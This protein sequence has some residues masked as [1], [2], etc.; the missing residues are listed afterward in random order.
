LLAGPATSAVGID[1]ADD[2]L[3]A[4]R[5]NLEAAGLS[6]RASLV[7]ADA[8]DPAAWPAGTAGADLILADPPWGSLHGSHA[9]AA[10]V[11][12]GLLRAAHA[13]AAPGARLVVLTHEVK[14]MDAAVRDAADLWRAREPVRV[15]AKGHHPRIWVLE[16]L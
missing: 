15:F 6:R 1:L 2:A 4:A 12:S 3:A 11:H 10:Q 9:T 14:V 13:A 16:K 8:L 5:D 7:T